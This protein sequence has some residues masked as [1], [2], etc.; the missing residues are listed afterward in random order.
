MGLLSEIFAECLKPIDR[1]PPWQWAE[2]HVVVDRNSP[3]PGPWRLANSPFVKKL[4]EKFPDNSIRNIALMTSAQSSKTLTIMILLEWAIDNDP[5]PAMWVQAAADEAATFVNNRL[6]PMFEDCEPIAKLMLS[7]ERGNKSRHKTKTSEIGFKT[8]TVW[9]TGSKSPSKLKS[10]PIRWLF[11]DEVSEY[12]PGA[13]DSV[14]KRVRSFWNSRRVMISTPRKADDAM[15]VAFK[16]GCQDEWHFACPRCGDMQPLVMAQMKAEHPET[17][18]ACLWSE[19]PGAFSGG[20]WDFDELAKA[21]RYECRACGHLMQDEPKVRQHIATV[22]DWIAMNPKASK[23]NYSAHWNAML[24]PI[25]KWREIVE[26]KIMADRALRLGD[27]EPLMEFINQTLGEPWEDRLREFDDFSV[28]EDR[29]VNYP[30]AYRNE[31]GTWILPEWLTDGDEFSSLFLAF[32]VQEKPFYHYRFVCRAFGKDRHTSRLVAYGKCGPE[33][34]AEAL[35]NAFGVPTINTVIDSA[36][37]SARVYKA[38]LKYKW[39][40]FRGDDRE[41]FTA[42]IEVEE[43]GKKVRKTVRRVWSLS[44]ADPA[45]GTQLQGKVRP[46]KLY[47]WSNPGV[48]DILA[49]AMSGIEQDWQISGDVGTDYMRE[50]TAEVREEKTDARGRVHY[51]WVKKR[52]D[53][54]YRDGELMVMVSAIMAK[55]IGR[56]EVDT[57]STEPESETANAA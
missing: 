15:H 38:C 18:E 41:A 55:K 52:K 51:E 5:G 27:V 28:L 23:K 29:K 37:D 46:I 30:L 33:E 39:K 47:L 42:T 3:Y 34:E 8:M 20:K 16:E 7:N 48:K 2:K 13:L 43:K 4:M 57:D 17:H 53:D 1:S 9:V 12:P 32:D 24:P 22:G 44:H 54:H 14:A 49:L 36:H 31:D 40:A 35:R 50:I 19:V 6:T 11:L 45:I 21:I 10:K 26:E 25:V 56:I